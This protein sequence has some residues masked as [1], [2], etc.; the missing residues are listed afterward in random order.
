MGHIKRCDMRKVAQDVYRLSGAWD[1]ADLGAGV[2]L[3]SAGGD[4]TLIDTGFRNK[5]TVI[6]R[7]IYRLGFSP[8]RI[9]HIIITHH[10]PDH[11][12]SLAALKN[13]TKAKV[14][15]HKDDVSYI[16]GS[17]PQPGPF[18]PALYKQVAAGF[19]GI[20]NTEPAAVDIQVEDN[21]ELPMAGG[22]RIIHTPGHTPGSM[23][24]YLKQKDL[25]FCGDLIARRLAIKLPSLAF[26]S[27]IPQLKQSIKKLA[28]R[29]FEVLCFGHGLPFRR[30][31][32]KRL[33]D[34]A[35]KV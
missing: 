34:F 32:G 23:C 20:L 16:D 30:N 19:K 18:R 17:L 5:A 22:I 31:A 4:L 2:Y 9:S 29:D 8:S 24:I 15:A 3:V 1:Q 26:T 21:D 13:I 27:D 12:G 35:A 10:H 33:K 25:V 11:I 14:V 7:R 6:M 28:E